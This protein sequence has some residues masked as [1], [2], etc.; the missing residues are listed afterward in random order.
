MKKSIFIISLVVLFSLF[1][2]CSTPK[3]VKYLKNPIGPNNNIGIIINCPNDIQNFVLAEYLK[4]GYEVKAINASDIYTISDVFDVKDYRRLAYKN[5][6][7]LSNQKLSDNVYKMHIYNFEL[8]KAQTLTQIKNTW[9]INYLIILDLKDWKSLSW[10]RAINL[11]S[12][13]VIWVENYPTK[14][15]DS[16]EDVIIHFADS[17]KTR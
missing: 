1:T 8:N 2:S 10:A 12:M 14:Y 17:M 9:N 13:S 5:S 6:E 7:I 11:N 4:R 3:G 16:L 15:K